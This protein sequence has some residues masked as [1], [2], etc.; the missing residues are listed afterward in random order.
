MTLRE[1]DADGSMLVAGLIGCRERANC[2]ELTIVDGEP[3]VT[4]WDLIA[5][6]PASLDKPLM[7]IRPVVG[8]D[9]SDDALTFRR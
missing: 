3:G 6:V 5:R 1:I 2:L 8:Y 7:V 4:L 9:V